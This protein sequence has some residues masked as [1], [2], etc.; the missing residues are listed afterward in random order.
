MPATMTDAHRLK[1]AQAHLAELS[2]AASK[3][4]EETDR[5]HDTSPAPQKYRAAFGAITELRAVL[6]KL[7]GLR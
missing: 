7:N 3:V 5:I 1:V 2:A 6:A 4:V